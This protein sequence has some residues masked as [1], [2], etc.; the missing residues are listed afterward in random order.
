VTTATRPDLAW[1]DTNLFVSL[2]ADESHPLHVRAL[3]LFRRVA[4][5]SLRLIVTPVVMAELVY[6]V[7]SLF[8]WRRRTVAERLGELIASEGLDVRETDAL[9][10]AL[11]LYGATARLDFADAYLAGCALMAGPSRVASLDRAFDRLAGVRRVS[12]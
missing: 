3:D 12:A 11:E 8:R 9:E 7:E 10:R 4:D 5:G 2:F 1:A 6:V